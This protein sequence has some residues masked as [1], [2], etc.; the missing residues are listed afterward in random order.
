MKE[1]RKKKKAKEEEEEGEIVETS[2]T[3]PTRYIF[4]NEAI[5]WC[6]VVHAQERDK[7]RKQKTRTAK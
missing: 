1:R 2:K 5:L 7:N 6:T 3:I 4:E